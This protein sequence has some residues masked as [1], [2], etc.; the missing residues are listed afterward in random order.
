[1]QN[2]IYDQTLAREGVEFEYA[3]KVSLDDIDSRKGL[4][5]QARLEEPL[6]EGLV[7]SYAALMREGVQFPP[8][9]LW[10]PGKGR[11]IPVDGNQ[12]LA[13]CH[14]AGKRSIDAYLLKTTDQLVIDRLTWCLNN[15]VNGKR[16]TRDEALHHAAAYVRK[17]DVGPKQ[18]SKIWGVKDGD[19]RKYVAVQDKKD[20]LDKHRVRLPASFSDEK[21]YKMAGLTQAGEDVF[22]RAVKAVIAT[23]V[24]GKEIVDLCDEIRSART[25]EA[26]LQVV[27]DFEKS[28]AAIQARAETQGGRVKPKTLPRQKLAAQLRALGRLFEDFE[29]VA[30]KPVGADFAPAREDAWRAVARLTA[31]FGLGSLPREGVG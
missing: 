1:M 7:E 8:L 27:A 2:P 12:R 10:R 3:D 4:A 14:K 5:N 23:G 18:A 19:L 17:Y 11:W 6:D 29:D 15:L 28:D 31:L 30:L 24:G 26:K 25:S 9:V 13:A 21:L 16:L 20:V 22:V